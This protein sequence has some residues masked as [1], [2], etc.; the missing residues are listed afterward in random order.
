MYK[1]YDSMKPINTDDY[2]HAI[3][4]ANLA[5]SVGVKDV[6]VDSYYI[7]W[8]KKE[9]DGKVS[10]EEIRMQN[11]IAKIEFALMKKGK[12]RPITNI[13]KD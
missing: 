7:D 13:K 1:S 11:A 5:S 10:S 9:N 2:Y 12:K 3:S 8:F 6:E 4:Q